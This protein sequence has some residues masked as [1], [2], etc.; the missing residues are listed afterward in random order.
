[1]EPDPPVDPD[2]VDPDPVDP[3][4]VDPDPVDPD[5]VDPDPV[6]PVD[7]NA[8]PQ[9]SACSKDEQC[10]PIEGTAGPAACYTEWRGE[11]LPGG[12]CSAP[13]RPGGCG[14]DGVC[15]EDDCV[16][17]CEEDSD[18]RD[19]YLCTGVFFSRFCWFGD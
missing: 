4:P 7:P 14:P 19:G 3:E 18:C 8:R 11:E 12:Y 15:I 17:R 13:C 9:G 5:P 2:P 6:D 10:A 16:A 1:M